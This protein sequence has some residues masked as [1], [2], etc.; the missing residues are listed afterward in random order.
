MPLGNTIVYTQS[1]QKIDLQQMLPVCFG[2]ESKKTSGDDGGFTR[3]DLKKKPMLSRTDP[4]AE[5]KKLDPRI[6]I[7]N[8]SR[9]WDFLL[10]IPRTLQWNVLNLY[11]RGRVLKIARPLR[12]Q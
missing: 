9:C 4:I 12:V 10:R 11:S 5:Q 3:K 6:R 7:P 1:C 2:E 8:R